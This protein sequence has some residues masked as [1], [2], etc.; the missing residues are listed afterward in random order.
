MNPIRVAPLVLGRE[1]GSFSLDLGVLLQVV[2]INQ[3]PF[4]LQGLRAQGHPD[5]ILLNLGS[6]LDG[7]LPFHLNKF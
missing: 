6:I 7:R 1:L 4:L 3:D 5:L 2:L